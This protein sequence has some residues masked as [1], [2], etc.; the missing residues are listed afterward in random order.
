MGMSSTRWTV[1][2]GGSN[3]I[4]SAIAHAF[5]SRGR[6]TIVLDR[7]APASGEAVAYER[8]DA[9]SLTDLERIFGKL[10]ERGVETVVCSTRYRPANTTDDV[11]DAAAWDLGI[12]ESLAPYYNVAAT[13]C[14]MRQGSAPLSLVNVSSILSE[15][16]T[17]S[18][19]MFYHAAKAAIESMTR[20]LAVRYGP[21]GVRANA[22]LPGLISKGESEAANGSPSAS[23][24][25]RIA[26]CVPLRRSGT[27]DEVAQAVVFLADATFVTGQSL[28]V[29]GGLSIVEQATV[30]ESAFRTEATAE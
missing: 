8:C 1:V 16:V 12:R 30:F 14:R 21:A 9:E 11:V 3:G 17:V 6:S 20:Y 4:G 10:R 23:A 28:I 29:D 13:A 27:I 26:T 7:T 22:V 19:P 25:A 15:L 18:Q 2:V 24:Y 5:A